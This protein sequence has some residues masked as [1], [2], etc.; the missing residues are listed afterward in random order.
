MDQCPKWQSVLA[1]LK[2]ETPILRLKR[3][4]STLSI[5]HLSRKQS[6]VQRAANGRSEPKLLI[7]CTAANVGYCWAIKRRSC[8]PLR[9]DKGLNQ[10]TL[11]TYTQAT[12]DHM[13]YRTDIADL[14]AVEIELFKRS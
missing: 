6:L 1:F 9:L 5:S 13:L 7:F 12:I 2:N 4:I 8:R 11:L 14:G 10:D 3:D